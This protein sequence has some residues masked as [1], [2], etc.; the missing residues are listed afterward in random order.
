M[1]QIIHY[2]KDKSYGTYFKK[3][4]EFLNR[5]NEHHEFIHFHWSRW[6]WMFARD[7]SKEED[8]E[9]I[10]LFIKDDEI[11]GAFI[12][13]DDPNDVYFAVYDDEKQLKVEM[14]TY[15]KMR[16]PNKDVIV[17]NDEEIISLLEKIDYEKTDWI[18]PVTRFSLNDFEVPETPGYN[19]VS[20]AEDYRLDQ[21]HHALYR[22]FNHGD[23]ITYTEKDLL[24]R[25]YETSS[26]H[27]SKA[28][29]YAAVYENKF[30]SYAGVWYMP[31][32]KTVL[33]EPVATTPE[34]R[35][36]Y[37]ARACIYACI[38][39]VM[40]DGAKDVFVG[41]NRDVYLNMGFKPFSHATRYKKKQ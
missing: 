8:L 31:G 32:T 38:K 22:G 12:F 36:N 2:P 1:Y 23:D 29:T 4:V 34:H 41:S 39:A 6:E 15:F 3:L 13:E 30:V 17:P 11:K 9:H 37:L 27:F 26:P 28:Y 10:S 35:R 7:S 24:G 21:I 33:V 14:I 16:N 19:I 40:K 25:K 20:L 18:D 5:H